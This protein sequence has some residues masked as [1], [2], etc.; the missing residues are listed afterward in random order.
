MKKRTVLP[1]KIIALFFVIIMG[2]SCKKVDI[3]FGESTIT[4]PNI[5]FI[6]TISYQLST[7]Q[8][9]SF[10]TSQSG[11][12]LIGR[13]TDAELGTMQAETYFH[14]ATPG[15]GRIPDGAVYDSAKLFVKLN[16]SYYGDTLQPF[17]LHAYTLSENISLED[18]NTYF[19]NPQQ[20]TTSA[21]SF[22]AATVQI[23][24]HYRIP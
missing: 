7:I 20:F 2:V 12:L 14:L 19:Y 5:A 10:I 9:D 23:G 18:N 15:T 6:D 13:H 1:I 8:S 11:A 24:Q 22:A 3:S 16:G 4:D 17:T 21:T